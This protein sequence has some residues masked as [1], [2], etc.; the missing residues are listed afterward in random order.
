MKIYYTQKIIVT[1]IS[2]IITSFFS[3]SQSFIILDSIYKTPISYAN[4]KYLNSENGVYSNENGIFTL[5]DNVPDSII[6]SCMGYYST[7]LN[8]LTLNDSI[9]LKPKIELLKEVTINGNFKTK[10]IGLTR[11]DSDYSSHMASSW[12][13]LT[14]LKFYEDYH[15]AFIQDISFD[16]NENKKI[17]KNLKA[18]VRINI[19]TF[20]QEGSIGEKIYTSTPVNYDISKADKLSF[21][22]FNER[23]ETEKEILIGIELIGFINK[24]NEVQN[25]KNAYLNLPF[26]KKKAKEFDSKTYFKFIFS[27]KTEW[28]PI[29]EFIKKYTN[30]RNDYYLPISLTIAVYED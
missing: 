6:V 12:E 21:N 16:I 25:D 27:D 20:N 1:S 5:G 2:I 18:V 3:Y 15:N 11:K 29:N 23:I 7:K 8:V 10:E 24:S 9:F 17:N 19:Y 4:I 28:M 22:V 26:S 14:H 13:Y 30:L